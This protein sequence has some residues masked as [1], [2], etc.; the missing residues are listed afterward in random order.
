M[1]K[2]ILYPMGGAD[3]FRG[4]FHLNRNKVGHV[5]K[6]QNVNKIDLSP[7]GC[8]NLGDRFFDPVGPT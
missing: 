7:I 8:D 3:G 6:Y 5:P 4:S 1:V 2:A